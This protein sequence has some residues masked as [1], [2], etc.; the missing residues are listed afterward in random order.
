MQS[1]RGWIATSRRTTVK[2]DD[3]TDVGTFQDKNYHRPFQKCIIYVGQVLNVRCISHWGS[4]L[5]Q[6]ADI[7]KI[8]WLE[9]TLRVPKFDYLATRHL[10]TNVYG[11]DTRLARDTVASLTVT[12]VGM[13]SVHPACA[14]GQLRGNQEDNDQARRYCRHTSEDWYRAYEICKMLLA[15]QYQPRKGCD[16]PWRE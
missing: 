10:L 16:R 13:R 14:L 9:A 3:V 2:A 15:D 6:P 8:W 4:E 12:K 1:H 7:A 11:T 5:L